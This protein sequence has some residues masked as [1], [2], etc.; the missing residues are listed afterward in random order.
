MNSI[1]LINSIAVAAFGMILSAAFCDILWTWR[2]RLIIAGSLA[3]SLSIQG[4]IYFLISPDIVVYFYPLITHLPLII[5]LYILSRKILW[6]TVSVLTAYLCCQTRRWLALLIV[7][8][9]SGNLMTQDAAEVILTLPILLL[10]L[11]FIAPSVRSVSHNTISAQWRFGLIPA[12]YYCF[13]Y[14]ASIYTNLLL[15]GTLVVVEFMPFVCS[16]AYLIFLVYSSTEGRIRLQLEQKQDVMNLQISQAVREIEALR[17]SQH[18]TRT[19][20]H[21]LRHHLQYVSSCIENGRYEQ[22]QGYIHEICSEIE[23][24]KVTIICENEAANLIFSAFVER[25][26]TA[27]IPITIDAALSQNISIS[28]NDLCVLLSNALENALHACQK[29]K[30]KGLSG[31]IDVSAYEK[32][33]KFFLQI[34][35]SCD[36]DIIFQDDIP[37]TSAHGHGIGVHSICAVVNK[38]DGIY[39]FSVKEDKFILRV[40]L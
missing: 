8:I 37:V 18:K 17:E 39:S 16:V 26:K 31:T 33:G 19:Y 2:K 14:L 40:S 29:R 21:D 10:L 24:N 27:G 1:Y 36:A 23:A 15:E 38:Y 5:V 12:L 13:D 6:S 22:A 3:V 25:A 30:E 20:N 34:I 35:N 9:F 11:R 4:L 28:E 32:N 7:T